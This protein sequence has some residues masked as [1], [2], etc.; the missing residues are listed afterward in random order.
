MLWNHNI[1]AV[2]PTVI[3]PTII[4]PPVCSIDY[5]NKVCPGDWKAVRVCVYVCVRVI[6]QSSS[7]T[8]Y[9]YVGDLKHYI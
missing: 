8:V 7:M 2:T 1:L 3:N 6:S 5:I 9:V 4:Y